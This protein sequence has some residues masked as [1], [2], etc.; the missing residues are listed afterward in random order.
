MGTPADNDAKQP[1]RRRKRRPRAAAALP[2]IDAS[3]IP[4]SDDQSFFER[5]RE[6]GPGLLVS[7][8]MHTIVL[9]VMAWY[10]YHIIGP[11]AIETID[12]GWGSKTEAENKSLVPVRIEA[13]NS[14]A[15]PPARPKPQAGAEKGVRKSKPKRVIQPVNVDD[16]LKD[17]NPRM[18][19]QRVLES[20]GDERTMRTIGT[21]LGWLKRQQQ[22]AGNWQLHQGYPNAGL[23]VIRTDTGATALALL[24]FLGAGHSPT[25]GE[26]HEVV[27]KGIQWLVGIQ[28]ADGN[29]H[30][31][32]E[33]GRQTAFYAHSQATIAICEA[34]LMSGNADLQDS[35]ERAV[36]FLLASQQPVTGGWKYRPLDADSVADLS[37]TGWAMMA[38]HSARAAG[39][40][41]PD[42][43]FKRASTFL[44]SVS[45]QDGERYKY[46]P[47]DP[48]SRVSIAMTAEGLLCRQF[49]G[50]T[51][52]ETSI[53]NGIEFL[54]DE[55]NRPQWA[56]GRRNVYAWYYVGHVI[57]NSDEIRFRE[58]YSSTAL[59]IVDSQ[60]KTGTTRRGKD[61][62]GSW[63]PEKPI[64]SPH[65]YSQKAGRLY[66]TSLCTLILELPFRYRGLLQ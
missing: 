17:R 1:P 23:S 7:L 5:L 56:A 63:H 21:A 25:D 19:A 43:S 13:F 8:V 55:N 62:R 31:H 48:P 2:V 6:G 40:A 66:L 9:V 4:G 16:L 50:A 47:T 28:K 29:F 45:E 58:W 32:D 35:A 3:T 41:V 30:D 65:E 14:S 24:P 49:L 57:H 51:R 52:S 11:A 26:H 15:E 20:G 10:T 38:L 39:I 64:G 44:D 59:L 12:V 53:A 46:E 54:L 33:L 60:T 61:V 37:V 42:E 36:G 22:S 27:A 34:Y 18:A